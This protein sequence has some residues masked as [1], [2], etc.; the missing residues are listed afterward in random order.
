[1]S[2]VLDYI[3][4]HQGNQKEILLY[5]HD[6]LTKELNL[7][8]K[9]RYK[10]PFYDRRS[11]ICY[12]NPIKDGKIELAFIRGKELSNNQGLLEF[13]KRKQ[14]AG[15]EFES[16]S[17]IPFEAVHEIIHEAILLDDKIPYKGPGNI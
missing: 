12:L 9:I 1:M 13:K 6:L 3:F 15:I 4:Q 8:S 16:L 5:F 14:I 11:W 10:I 7:T 2:A 17:Q